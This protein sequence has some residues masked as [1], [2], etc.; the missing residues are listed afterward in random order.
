MSKRSA[1][2]GK[3]PRAA[4]L[5]ALFR[6]LIFFNVFEGIGGKAGGRGDL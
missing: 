6:Q 3:Q 4:A 2:R 5:T 1:S